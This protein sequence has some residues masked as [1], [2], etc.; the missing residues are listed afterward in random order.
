[1]KWAILIVTIFF[2]MALAAQLD[3]GRMSRLQGCQIT[4]F[5]SDCVRLFSDRRMP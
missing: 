4:G 3:S 2:L 1:M 5:K